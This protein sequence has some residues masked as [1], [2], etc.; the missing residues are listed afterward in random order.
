[1][2]PVWLVQLATTSKSFEANPI[3]GSLLLNRL[4]LHVIRVVLSHTIMGARMYILSYQVSK[5]DRQFYRQNGYLMKTDFLAPEAF[6]QLDKEAR[7][8]DGETREGRQGNTLTQRAVMSPEARQQV[9]VIATLLESRAFSSLAKFT[10]GTFRAPFYYIDFRKRPI[11][12][13]TR[14]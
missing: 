3:I 4:G 13:Y 9:P 6:E 10:A 8:Y 12:L 7:D 2:I 1:M 5:Q 14:V 11:Y